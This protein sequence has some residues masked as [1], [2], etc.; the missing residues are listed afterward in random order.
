MIKRKLKPYVVPALYSLTVIVF[1]LSMYFIE[2]LVNKT[3]FSVDTNNLEYVDNNILEKHDYLPVI[4]TDVNIVRPYVNNKVYVAKG[5]Y[6]Y[7]K[8]A[9]DQEKSIIYYENTYMQ[10]SGIDYANEEE[11]DIVSILD[12][13]VIDIKEDK[14]LG[15][16]VEI[17][18]TSDLISVYQS[19]KDVTV[20]VND[21]VKQGQVI[22]KSGTSNIN[23]EL[24]NHLHFE[25]Y[26]QGTIVNP[27]EYYN[28][29]LKEL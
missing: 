18:H 8:E 20:K 13:T 1:I 21:I 19:L 5:F 9:S 7:T 28:K 15:T 6:D 2:R 4:S 3:T 12:G 23:P 11:F 16:T 27:E 29:S 10:N 17:R 26:Y 24:N 14:I 25:L 22:A